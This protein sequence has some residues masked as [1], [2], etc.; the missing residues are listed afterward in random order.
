MTIDEA[1]AY[2][3]NERTN[4]SK[5]GLSRIHKLLRLLGNPEKDM[6]LIHVVGTNGKGSVTA[7]L[8]AV[9]CSSG[10]RV[11]TMS[12]PALKGLKDYYRVQL[13]DISD[14]DYIDAV[15]GLQVVCE[16]LSEEDYPTEFEMSVA[17]AILIF[18]KKECEYVVLEAGMG[19]GKDATHLETPGILT[20]MTHIA[21]DHTKY[22][23][24]TVEQIALEK[25]AIASENEPVVLGVNSPD[26]RRICDMYCFE[27]GNP[28]LY[29]EDSAIP[30]S[31]NS[32]M[33]KLSLPGIFQQENAKTVLAAVYALRLQD[34]Y[35]N[36]SAI[37]T[38]MQNAVLPYR[39]QFRS[40][41]PYFIMDGGHNPDCIRALTESLCRLPNEPKFVIL[42]GVMADKEYMTMY[43]MLL[44][45]GER[46]ITVTPDNPR[47]LPAKKL[48]KYL[49]SL[50]ANAK[51]ANSV[52]K[53][54]ELA[55]SYF[56]EG[57]N[58]LCTGTLYMMT[59][60]DRAFRDNGLLL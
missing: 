16:A 10:Y 40:M 44:P 18:H 57:R 52:D 4:V 45:F 19:G 37:R 12:S 43:P 32:L 58:I 23:G 3:K 25:I 50:G 14:E 55:V 31:K 13:K 36:D 7:M 9:L 5:P 39:F 30:F 56:R 28:F 49:E 26:I 38:G 54:A 24:E 2:V 35:I 59:D 53:G 51:A 21:K 27:H 48:Q 47:A 20:V 42:T 1:Y 17:I 46:F 60:L 6:K 33:I 11:G 22:L 34:V 8:S 41:N 15:T 29:A